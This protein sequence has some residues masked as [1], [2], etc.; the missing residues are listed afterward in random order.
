MQN[1]YYCVFFAKLNNPSNKQ[2][3]SEKTLAQRQLKSAY[4]T[5][6][7]PTN[8]S[9]NSSSNTGQVSNYL[10]LNSTDEAY[11][12]FRD[13]YRKQTER[14]FQEEES[15]K[16]FMIIIFAKILVIVVPV[17]IAVAFFT[18]AERKILGSIQRRRGPNVVGVFG[19]FQALA[20]GLKLFLKETI[21]SLGI[22][23]FF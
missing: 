6:L 7:F 10:N 3:S 12:E 21:L 5:D 15:K 4:S 16:V 2:N 20:D 23:T 22:S 13:Y 14:T 18:V 1:L 8:G 9:L 11:M 17:L 19:L